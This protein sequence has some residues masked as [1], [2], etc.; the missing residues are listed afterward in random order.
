MK[1][2]HISRRLRITIVLCIV[3]VGAIFLIAMVFQS[4]YRYFNPREFTVI[5]FGFGIFPIIILWGIIWIFGAQ[6]QS[7]KH[8][9][10]EEIKK[11]GKLRKSYDEEEVYSEIDRG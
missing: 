11:S 9:L 8:R 4:S 3:W 5:F 7:T 1:S 2:D 6:K 10:E